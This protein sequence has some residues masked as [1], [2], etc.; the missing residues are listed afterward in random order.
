MKAAMFYGPKEVKI[1]D[2]DISEVGNEDV[3][4]K[5][6]VCG[7]CGTDKLIFDG[8]YYASFPLI[9]GHEYAG[10]VVKIGKEVYEIEVGDK[11]AVDPNIFCQKCFYC[12]HGEGNLCKNFNALGV[13]LNGGF[14]EYSV[15]PVSNVYKIDNKVD[16]FEAAMVEPLACCIRGF[17]RGN[18]EFG[19]TV[20]IFGN[21]P[22]GNLILQLSKISGVS[23]VIV[24]EPLE[25]RRKL[26]LDL[27]ADYVFDSK[28]DYVEK[29][30]K[31]I[32]KEGAD[33]VFECSGNQS[34][35]EKSIYLARRGGKIIYF[36]CSPE[37]QINSISPFII[38]ENELT[39]KGSF[40]NPYTTIKAV[41]L[42]SRGI[43]KS[44]H[45][46]T[47]KLSLSEIQN[48]FK[49]FGSEGVIKILIVND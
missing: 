24:I 49:I 46:I 19:D 37:Q 48:A 7:V 44:K 1:I 27:G 12:K 31:K 41:K 8:K 38:N 3:L 14:A 22:I 45:L 17:E 5:V 42:I 11:V 28:T 40:N 10:E 43:I 30:I 34:A 6:K 21:G 39:I 15:V 29:E 36:G 13:T 18:V 25:D 23:N 26:A 4:I 35:Q 9:L 16:F 20:V 33:V 2:M 32:E 47:H